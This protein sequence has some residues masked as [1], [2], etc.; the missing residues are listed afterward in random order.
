MLFEV[1]ESA[2]QIYAQS[3]INKLPNHHDRM[4]KMEERKIIAIHH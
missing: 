1:Q 3:N 4:T 2:V